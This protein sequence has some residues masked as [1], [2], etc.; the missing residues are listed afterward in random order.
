M[1]KSEGLRL[2]DDFLNSSKSQRAY[3]NE[4]DI[5]RSTLRYWL[6][7]SEEIA[8]GTVVV[9]RQIVLGGECIC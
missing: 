8:D 1:I 3:C 4:K 9:F 2:V 6:K 7:R 5:K